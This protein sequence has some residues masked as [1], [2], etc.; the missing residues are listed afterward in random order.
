MEGGSILQGEGLYKIHE[1]QGQ[2]PGFGAEVGLHIQ[3]SPNKKLKNLRPSA[4]WGSSPGELKAWRGIDEPRDHL[5]LPQC[6]N[7]LAQQ[8]VLTVKPTSE[9]G[10]RMPGKKYSP[11]TEQSRKVGE[12][13]CLG[14]CMRRDK[15]IKIKNFDPPLIGA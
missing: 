12:H 10:I 1:R 2:E 6:Q 13:F 7:H 4:P 9:C 5:A 3:T 15:N 14:T 8:Q 11:T